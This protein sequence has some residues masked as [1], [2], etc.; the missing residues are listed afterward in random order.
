MQ[1]IA[2]TLLGDMTGAKF[3]KLKDR[4][5]THLTSAEGQGRKGIAC[6]SVMSYYCDIYPDNR[7]TTEKKLLKMAQTLKRHC[8]KRLEGG[9]TKRAPACT[10]EYLRILMNAL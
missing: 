3:V 7:A 5:V 10:M 2:S 8:L 4:F 1:F 6:N 9:A